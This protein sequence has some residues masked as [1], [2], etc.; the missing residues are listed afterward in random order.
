MS[1]LEIEQ[2]AL[3]LPDKEKLKLIDRLCQSIGGDPTPEWHGDTLAERRKRIESGE[4]KFYT[5]EEAM[6]K[7][8]NWSDELKRR[9]RSS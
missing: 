5:L 7:M 1:T 2:Q 3:A 8:N 9:K 6:Q 4:A